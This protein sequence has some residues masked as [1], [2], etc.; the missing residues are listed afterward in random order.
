MCGCVV[1]AIAFLPQAN[2]FSHSCAELQTA[3]WLGKV[4]GNTSLKQAFYLSNPC[5]FVRI[6]LAAEIASG[7][8]KNE[9]NE[10]GVP[11][12]CVR[13][14]GYAN[15]GAGCAFSMSI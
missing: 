6:Y 1:A 15:K 12:K 5:Y 8:E 10:L 14:G 3:S 4:N 7:E 11:A 9:S 13:K 2:C